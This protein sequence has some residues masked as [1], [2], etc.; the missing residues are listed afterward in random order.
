VPQFERKSA[1]DFQEVVNQ[2]V[3]VTLRLD[4]LILQPRLPR[5]GKTSPVIKQESCLRLGQ[6]AI[7]GLQSIQTSLFAWYSVKRADGVVLPGV[8]LDKTLMPNNI[9]Q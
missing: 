9:W 5:M 8:T 7:L 1:I 6:N 2:F 4:F 3:H